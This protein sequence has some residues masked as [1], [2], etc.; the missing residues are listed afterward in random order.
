MRTAC[1]SRF[2][3]AFGGVPVD[4]YVDYRERWADDEHGFIVEAFERR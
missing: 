1:H 2:V 3:P 4:V